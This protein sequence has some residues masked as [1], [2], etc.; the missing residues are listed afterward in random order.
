M[1][2]KGVSDWSYNQTDRKDEMRKRR[3]IVKSLSFLQFPLAGL[4]IFL[5]KKKHERFFD[6]VSHILIVTLCV[7]YVIEQAFQMNNPGEFVFRSTIVV[8]RSSLILA[9]FATNG[10]VDILL[11]LLSPTFIV[12]LTFKDTKF[13]AGNLQIIVPAIVVILLGCLIFNFIVCEIQVRLF[14]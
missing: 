8:L 13:E 4:M 5:G 12:L 11:G 14:S 6:C 3:L 9:A 7:K 10:L 2:T 1:A